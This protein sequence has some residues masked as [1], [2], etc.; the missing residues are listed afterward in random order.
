MANKKVKDTNDEIKKEAISNQKKTKLK[1]QPDIKVSVEEAK[2]DDYNLDDKKLKSENLKKMNKR[3]EKSGNIK[4]I[5]LIFLIVLLAAICIFIFLKNKT[6][7]VKVEDSNALTDIL[8]VE[9]ATPDGGQNVK[10]G[11]ENDSIAKI[12]YIKTYQG[13]E[14]LPFTLRSST[15]MEDDLVQLD[16]EFGTPI[17]MES[18]CNDGKKVSVLAQV[19]LTDE[20]LIMKAEWMDND[21]YYAMVTTKLTTREDFLQEVNKVIINTH[22]DDYTYSREDE[23]IYEEENEEDYDETQIDVGTPSNVEVET[24]EEEPEE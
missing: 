8:G 7:Y 20:P 16:Y 21:N 3:D 18:I 17:V 22:I 23:T 11:I 5:T 24:Y 10:Y 2:N 9:V 15:N 6:N 4:F 12:D 14:K 13:G 1:K 19:A